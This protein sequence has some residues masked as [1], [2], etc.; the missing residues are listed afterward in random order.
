MRIPKKYY[1]LVH[2]IKVIYQQE[3]IRGFYKGL[4]ASSILIPLNYVIYFNFYE[5]LKSRV[6]RILNAK[7]TFLCFAIPS[8]LSGLFTN[9]I[10]SPL[11]VLKTR[12]QAD[13]YRGIKRSDFALLRILKGTYQ[14]V[15]F[16]Y[17]YRK[18]SKHCIE[19][20]QQVL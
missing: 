7:D 3:G 20:F 4:F 12:L 2:A 1:S 9:L 11:W 10:L 5:M 6:R 17:Y 16:L 14:L 19:G 18:G 8:A 13:V 15:F